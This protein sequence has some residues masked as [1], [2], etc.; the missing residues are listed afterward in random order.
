LNGINPRTQ[1]K[2]CDVEL[3]ATGVQLPLLGLLLQA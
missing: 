3:T 2:S 1:E